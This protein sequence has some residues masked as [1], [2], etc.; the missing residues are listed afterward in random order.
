LP[1]RHLRIANHFG[2]PNKTQISLITYLVAQSNYVTFQLLCVVA[3]SNDNQIYKHTYVHYTYW[4]HIKSPASFNRQQHPRCFARQPQPQS[5]STQPNTLFMTFFK[6][7]FLNFYFTRGLPENK[8]V[9]QVL[10]TA[11]I[12]FRLICG[13]NM[14]K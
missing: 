8:H 6:D 7:I 14:Y 13:A 4:D 1:G 11:N 12:T 9:A 3:L 10:T 2:E 5:N